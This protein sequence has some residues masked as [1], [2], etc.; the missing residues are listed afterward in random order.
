MK[1]GENCT[2]VKTSGHTVH[3]DNVTSVRNRTQGHNKKEV[4]QCG[5]SYSNKQEVYFT[6]KSILN[7]IQKK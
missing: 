2:N 5:E 3:S 6:I 1:Q 4:S 7:I